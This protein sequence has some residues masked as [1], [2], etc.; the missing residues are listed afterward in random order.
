MA[1]NSNFD[2]NIYDLRNKIAHNQANSSEMERYLN[3]LL[4]S[5]DYNRN[6]V[7]DYIHEIGYESVNDFQEHL[8]EKNNKELIDGLL[9]IGGAVLF[10]YLLN[11]IAE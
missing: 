4:E 1:H 2:N 11:K 10:G 8:N 6:V 7:E 5:S 9:L 3:L